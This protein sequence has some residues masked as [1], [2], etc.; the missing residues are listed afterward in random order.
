MSVGTVLCEVEAAGIAL[1]LDGERIRICFPEPQHV[2]T[3]QDG[4][5]RT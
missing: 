4:P 2:R 1:R 3:D 5:K